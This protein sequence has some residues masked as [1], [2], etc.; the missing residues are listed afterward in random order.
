MVICPIAR[1][2]HCTSCLFVKF[3]PAKKILG[4]YGK[5]S[6]KQAIADKETNKKPDESTCESTVQP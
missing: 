1:A 3:C 6:D 4:D 5:E 2:V